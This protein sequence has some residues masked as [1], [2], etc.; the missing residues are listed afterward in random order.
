MKWSQ[1]QNPFKI[2]DRILIDYYAV[3]KKGTISSDPYI[4]GQV[5]VRFDNGTCE[6]IHWRMCKKLKKKIKP[7]IFWMRHCK[8]IDHINSWVISEN[9]SFSPPKVCTEC[10]IIHVR[11]VK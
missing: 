4:S 10:E 8:I 5:A 11:E 9:G 3:I 7:R 2:G 1:K 6:N